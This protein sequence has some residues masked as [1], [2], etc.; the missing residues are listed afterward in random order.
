MGTLYLT[1][2]RIIFV[3]KTGKKTAFWKNNQQAMS[4]RFTDIKK[5]RFNQPMFGANNIAGLVSIESD[6]GNVDMKWK[7]TFNNGGE[8]TFLMAFLKC[9]KAIRRIRAYE[10]RQAR[11]NGVVT[12]EA[13]AFHV[14]AVAVDSI[15]QAPQDARDPTSL[16]SDEAVFIGELADEGDDEEYNV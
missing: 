15:L 14:D 10:E 13:F 3:P 4:I 1:S 6:S 9:M 8:G 12:A 2:A 16:W 11:E 5:E 7:F